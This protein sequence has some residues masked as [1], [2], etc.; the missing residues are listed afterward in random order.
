M[1]RLQREKRLA[2]FKASQELISQENVETQ[3][4]D[5]VTAESD[6]VIENEKKVEEVEKPKKT[7]KKKEKTGDDSVE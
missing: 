6:V 3:I 7:T 4:T 1:N 5:S 2:A